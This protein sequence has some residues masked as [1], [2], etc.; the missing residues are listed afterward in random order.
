MHPRLRLALEDID[1]AA[2]TLD[3]ATL[4]RPMPGK[5]SIAE[6][7]EH[8]TLAFTVNATALE[9]VL[10]SGQ[11]RTRRPRLFQRIGRFLVV[12][13]GCFPRVDAPA[14]TRPH[15]SIPPE[16][17]LAAIRE[18]IERVDA[19]LSRVADRFGERVPV[20]H[21]PILGPFSVR[22]WRKFHWRHTAHH[23]R[24]IRHRESLIPHP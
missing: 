22:H 24:Q 4:A 10:Q 12:E 19:T 16:R 15:G 8:L 6:I 20:A 3:A 21:H 17:S 9:K 1:D 2:G 5:W 7:L 14:V 18:S 11:L 13:A 23:M